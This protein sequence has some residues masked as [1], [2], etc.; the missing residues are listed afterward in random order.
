MTFKNLV[1][2]EA[3]TTSSGG[4]GKVLENLVLSGPN[5]EDMYNRFSC[6]A[7]NSKLAHTANTRSKP[8][9]L[10]TDTDPDHRSEI[11]TDV[12]IRVLF[13]AGTMMLEV[14][15]DPQLTAQLHT[16]VQI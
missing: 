7:V 13:K 14:K 6:F 12:T 16:T 9:R 2:S 4:N 1:P 10:Y 8:E 3:E 11:I 15:V 5:E